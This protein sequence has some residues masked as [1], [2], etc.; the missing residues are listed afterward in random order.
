MVDIDGKRHYAC[1]TKIKDGMNITTTTQEIENE[2]IAIMKSYAVNH[3]LECGVC[4]K[5]GECGLQDY[6]TLMCV[7]SQ[8]FCIEPSFLP[9]DSWS[10]IKYD[11][12]LYIM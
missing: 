10:N 4:D 12:S 2:R 11:P 6:V 5:S 1:N 7:D 9:M 8:D 3:P